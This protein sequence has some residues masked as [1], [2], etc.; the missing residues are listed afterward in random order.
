MILFFRS[1]VHISRLLLFLTLFVNVCFAQI[2]PQT[3][4]EIYENILKLNTLGNALYVAA[5]PDDENTL[6]IS[7][8]SK[9]RKLRTA[10]IAMTRGD[11][12]QNLIG[13]EQSEYVGLLRTHELLEARKVDGGEQYFTRAVD[14]GYSKSTD[15]ALQKW[16]KEQ[17]L[18]DLVLRIRKFKPDVV[19][20]R[21]PTDTRAGHGHHSASAVLSAEAFDAANDPTK[22]PDQVKK[23]GIWQV[24]RVVWNSYNRGFTNTKPEEGSYVPIPLGDFNAV[25]GKSYPEI[26]AEAR[27]KHRSQGFGS[28]PTRNDRSDFAIAIKGTNATQDVLDGIDLTW[29]RVPQGKAIAKQLES[30]VKNF[31]FKMPNNSTGDLIKLYSSIEKMPDNHFK[32]NKLNECLN[33]ILA[34]SGI[35]LEAFSQQYYTT[36]GDV[37]KVF[38]TAVNRSNNKITLHKVSMRGQGSADSLYS[39]VLENNKAFDKYVDVKMNPDALISQP[40]WMINESQNGIYTIDNEDLN[41][42]PMAPSA[43]NASFEFSINGTKLI[44]S[45]PV[46]YKY[47]EPSR[48][49]IY[50]YFEVRPPFMANLDQKVY[51]FSDSQA[52][53]V[54]VAVR[55]VNPDTLASVSLQV[56]NGWIYSPTSIPLRF[57]EKNQELKVEFS[58]I[59]PPNSSDASIEAIVKYKGKE[60]SRGLKTISYE[61]IPE[62]NTFP[63]SKAKVSK[64]DLVKKGNAI[65]YIAGAGDEVPD[66]LRQI[67][68]QVDLLTEKEVQGGLAKYDAILIGVRA[69]NTEDW[70]VNAQNLL[71][72]Y[73]K[74]GGRMIVQ[75]QTQAFYGTVKTK[76]LGPYS[77][78]IGRGRITDENAEMKVLKPEEPILNSPNKINESDY[79]NWVQERGL[80]FAEKWSDKYKT[81]FSIKDQGETDQEGALLYTPYGKGYYVFTGLSFF[82]QLPAGVPGAFRLMAN[83]ISVG[84]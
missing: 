8:L 76:E 69:Y 77:L 64:V 81:V 83:L 79:K 19:I 11:G 84:L 9:E 24:K 44:Y 14:F 30:I 27:S 33:L 5:H 61:H 17:I 21:F 62:L 20:N 25:L 12:G 3:S 58:L 41:G 43:L 63:L 82:R 70:L 80:Y 31:N 37:S 55:C 29:N 42:L 36:P 35:Y 1:Q 15:E 47:T 53:K 57:T 40:Y 75:Y 49:E 10:Y 23:Y 50:K 22:F 6:L 18:S 2:K 65:G 66:A 73:V 54:K 71:F 68:Y 59:P 7:Y 45:H 46:R 38:F 78:S 56:P 74:N 34:C 16:G 52:K 32:E 51:L 72:D 48:G 67:G 26:A 28:A 4:S 13:S 39:K 60:Y